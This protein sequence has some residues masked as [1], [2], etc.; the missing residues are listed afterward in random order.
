MLIPD[1]LDIQAEQNPF[2]R[3][4]RTT[5]CLE[6]WQICQKSKIEVVLLNKFI[7]EK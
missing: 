7:N 5:C 4:T 3:L 1:Y 6:N 2:E